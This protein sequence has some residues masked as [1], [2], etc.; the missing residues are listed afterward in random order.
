LVV[1]RQRRE[2]EESRSAADLASVIA[3]ARGALIGRSDCTAGEAAAQLADMAAAAGLPVPEMA[4]IVLGS[5][6]GPDSEGAAAEMAAGQ[7]PAGAGPAAARWSLRDLLAAAAASRARDGAEFVEALASQVL[8]PLG[9]TALAVWLLG[10]DGAL[11]LLG[12]RGLTG[13]VASRWRRLP[14]Y[15][16]CPPQRLVSGGAELWWHAGPP[17]GD[18]V[19]MAARWGPRAGRAVLGLRRHGGPLLG[20]MQVWWPRPLSEFS[21]ET[22]LWLSALAAGFADVLGARLAQDGLQPSAA[23]PPVFTLLDEIT[24]SVLVARPVRD[25]AGSVADFAID[26]L[27]GA[28]I[29]PL[30]RPA[31]TLA[32]LTLLEAYPGSGEGTGLFA[33][34]LRVLESGVPEH[35][36]GALTAPLGGLAP[37]LVT[38]ADL[39]AAPFFDGVIFTWREATEA[40]RIAELLDHGQRLGRLGAWSENL[41][42]GTTFWTDSA[43]A[44][45]G[46]DPLRAAP[47]PTADLHNLVIASDRKLVRRFRERL[48][49]QREAATA[50]FR[51]I[52]PDCGGHAP[53]TCRQC[54]SATT[55]PSRSRCLTVSCS[56]WTRTPGTPPPRSSC[57]RGHAGAVHRRADRAARPV[58]H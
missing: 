21:A 7:P 44:V 54:W 6:P 34:A 29:D 18:P 39:H 47:I 42:E 51:L 56:A 4:A 43:F 36:P 2:L 46:L 23:E 3:M 10:A 24:E 28:Y 50:V 38:V 49:R 30:G 5:P 33:R 12:E 13:M 55:R 57:A 45:F 20:V 52:R 25:E 26:H 58:D 31:A 14:P 17:P 35:V 27:G 32:R 40:G 11:E 41:A 19:V 1:E 53:A 37:D 48:L 8:A 9:A 16:D 15:F 22:R